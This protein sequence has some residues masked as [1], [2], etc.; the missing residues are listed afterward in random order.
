MKFLVHKAFPVKWSGPDLS[1]LQNNIAME[2]L[3]LAHQGMERIV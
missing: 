2:T 3:E 1:A